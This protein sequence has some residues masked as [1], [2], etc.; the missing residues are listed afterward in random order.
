[1]KKRIYIAMAEYDDATEPMR[2][3]VSKEEAE[4]YIIDKEK[5]D[6]EDNPNEAPFGDYYV[7]EVWLESN[8]E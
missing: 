5:Q 2:A 4:M 1:M 8:F 6:L 3:F 7:D